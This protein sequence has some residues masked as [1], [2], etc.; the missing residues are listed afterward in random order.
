MQTT[1]GEMANKTGL[2]CSVDDL[3]PE[4]GHPNAQ[5]RGLVASSN[6]PRNSLDILFRDLEQAK[7]VHSH[8]EHKLFS[9]LFPL[10]QG[11]FIQGH[12]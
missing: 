1:S 10:A 11:G 6:I 12:N 7:Q 8:L 3:L 4:A 5:V 9:H 2:L